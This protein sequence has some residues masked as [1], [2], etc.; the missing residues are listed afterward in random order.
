MRVFGTERISFIKLASAHSGAKLM[1]AH[2]TDSK[3]RDD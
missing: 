2:A 3:R 1:L